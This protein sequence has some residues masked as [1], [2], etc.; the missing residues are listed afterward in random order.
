MKDPERSNAIADR[1]L[2]Q[3]SG[4]SEPSSPLA[5]FGHACYNSRRGGDRPI[6]ASN[7]GQGIRRLRLTADQTFDNQQGKTQVGESEPVWSYR[8]YHLKS[9]EFTTAMV[10]FFRAEVQRANVWRQR[11]ELRD[12]CIRIRSGTPP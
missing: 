2:S 7:N 4:Q 8:G 6:R 5:A 3:K 11:L 12:G 9:S 1:A 10:H